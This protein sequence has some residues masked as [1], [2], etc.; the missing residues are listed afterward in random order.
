MNAMP[1]EIETNMRATTEG[2]V[3]SFDGRWTPGATLSYR[4]PECKHAMLPSTLGLG[5]KEKN[6]DEWAAHF[7]RL[8][9]IVTNAK[10][11]IHDYLAIPNER[12]AVCRTSLTADTPVGSYAND[13]VW[14]FTFD[15]DG[16]KIVSITEFMDSKAGAEML[17]KLT[18][19]GLFEKH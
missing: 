8:D 9:G 12:R 3:H 17:R 1:S 13:Y 7:K 14:F 16:G 11:T 5:T 10:T 2:F 18:D 4:S 6:N 15:E 19:A